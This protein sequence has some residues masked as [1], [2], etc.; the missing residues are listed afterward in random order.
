M[1]QRTSTITSANSFPTGG[2][3]TSESVCQVRIMAGSIA[4]LLLVIIMAGSICDGVAG[5]SN[6]VCRFVFDTES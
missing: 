4:V 6:F 5:G 1:V 3:I 2:S